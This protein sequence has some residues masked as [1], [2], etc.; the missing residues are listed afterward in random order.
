MNEPKFCAPHT[1][2]QRFWHEIGEH[3][4]Y[5][6]QVIENLMLAMLLAKYG[7]KP[8]HTVIKLEGIKIVLLIASLDGPGCE[9]RI[10]IG[11]YRYGDLG[12]VQERGTLLGSNYMHDVCRL[13]SEWNKFSLRSGVLDNLMRYSDTHKNREAILVG[14]RAMGFPGVQEVVTVSDAT[15]GLVPDSNMIPEQN[16]LSKLLAEIEI[17]Y[18]QQ[19]QPNPSLN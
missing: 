1:A 2:E 12:A 7:V 18:Y 15:S 19:G 8:D 14:V 6:K 11:P 10:D 4:G 17:S 9:I 3:Y 16:P 5:S 13:R